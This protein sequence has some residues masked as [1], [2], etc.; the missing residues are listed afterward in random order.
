MTAYNFLP[1]TT[2]PTRLTHSSSTLIDN[3]FYRPATN[4]K[5]ND[6]AN[7]LTRIIT[8]DIADHLANLVILLAR[9]K[10]LNKIERPL[11]RSVLSE[12]RTKHHPDKTSPWQNITWQN[13]T[14]TKHHPGQNITLDKTSPGQN[15]TQ[16]KTSPWTKHHPG[17]NITLDKTSPRTKHHPGQN[18]TLDKTS[19]R[20]KH[21]P[22]KTSPWQNI[23]QAF[24]FFYL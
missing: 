6:F 22:D 17:Q 12:S 5:S 1:L 13:I 23:T 20:T 7:C 9:N 24:P 21:H 2:L 16:D 19:P 18:I 3:I 14:W 15:I 8:V 4:S 10:N 11:V